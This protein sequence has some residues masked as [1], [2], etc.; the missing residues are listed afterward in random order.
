M[1]DR[2]LAHTTWMLGESFSLAD[3][4]LWHPI[5]FLQSEPSSFALAQ[6]FPDLMRWFKRV[7]AMGHGKMKGMEPDEAL[8]IAR[9]SVPSTGQYEDS[10]DP[11]GLKLGAKVAVTPDDYGFDPVV[12]E[13]VVSSIYEIAIVRDDPALGRIVNHFPKVGFHIKPA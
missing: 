5:W 9:D 11:N 13:V 12:G 3:A 2:Q 7:D 8:K 4:A 6:K 1:M 10:E